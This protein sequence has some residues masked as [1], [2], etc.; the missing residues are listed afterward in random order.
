MTDTS[1]AEEVDQDARR[2]RRLA[3]GI[4]AAKVIF[5]LALLRLFAGPMSRDLLDEELLPM[6]TWEWVLCALTP[7][8]LIHQARRPANWAELAGERTFLRIALSC[9]LLYALAFA[10]FQDVRI[11]W[12]AVAAGLIGFGQI[13]RL[14]GKEDNRRAR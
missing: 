5:V 14:D 10:M 6:P 4:A 9:Y 13:W 1:R 2:S 3:Y 12:I 7:S 11:L 8:L